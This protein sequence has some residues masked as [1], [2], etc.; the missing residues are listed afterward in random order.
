MWGHFPEEIVAKFRWL[1]TIPLVAPNC[2]DEVE[3]WKEAAEDGGGAR[4]W[5]RLDGSEAFRWF[6]DCLTC[7]LIGCE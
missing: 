7:E 5:L 3:T 1:S 6:E 2:P 4:C